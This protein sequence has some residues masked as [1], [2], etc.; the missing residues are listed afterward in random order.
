MVSALRADLLFGMRRLVCLL[1]LLALLVPSAAGAR[2]HRVAAIT[3]SPATLPAGTTGT[4]Y[5]QALSGAGGTGPYTFAVT[6]GALPPGLSLSSAGLLSG[7]PT[8]A[9]SYAF[10]VT[11]TDSLSASGPQSY[12]LSISPA[13]ISLAPVTLPAAVRAAAYSTTLTASGGTAPY[14]YSVTSGTLP[15]GLS[16]SAAGVLSGTP[17]A[18]GSFTFT[19]AAVDA[20]AAS[21]SRTYTL[22][23]DVG[24]LQVAPLTLGDATAGVSYNSVLSGSGGTGPYS[25]AVTSGT[26]TPGL[27]LASNGVL[28]GVPSH[29]GTYTFTVRMTDSQS[30]TAT[31]TYDHKVVV[32]ALSISPG[33][34]SDATYAKSYSAHLSASGGTAPYTFAVAG[35]AL[36]SG[37]ALSAAGELSGAPTAWGT[38]S[39]SVAASDPYGS[40]GTY[41]YTLVVAAPTL[42]VTPDT[43]YPATA[44]LFY[45]A[46]LTTSGGVGAYAYTLVSGS[47]P[48]GLSLTPD[49]TLSGLPDDVPGLYTFTVRATDS[50]GAAGTKT[51]TLQMATPTIYVT[52]LALPVAT[53]K[54]AYLQSLS[55]A[56]GSLPYSFVLA[57]GTLPSGISLSAGGVLSGTPT[58]PGTFLFTVKITD[59][60]G[61][62]ATQSFRLVVQKA[63]PTVT[64]KKPPKKKRKTKRA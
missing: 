6:A 47:F 33:L 4:S 10:T 58:A 1:G 18:T 61:V 31:R 45:S 49:G 8:S 64:K 35:G 17:A 41:P 60:K 22:S 63:A 51:Y 28:T 27:S 23:V 48:A 24:A 12:T 25:F 30:L 20:N 59:A 21:G 54:S 5:S 29:V 42:V 40:S 26:L 37:L 9:G 13:T 53:V 3:I 16:L 62:T 39:F 11:A 2:A 50:H 36:P 44:D 52:S 19:V 56:G 43:L 38:Y 14:A 57:D 46:T 15:L 32:S 7:T 34:L 55:V